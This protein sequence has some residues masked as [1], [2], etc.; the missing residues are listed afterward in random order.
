MVRDGGKHDLFPSALLLR[1][2]LQMA[3]RACMHVS[4]R[5]LVH[6]YAAHVSTLH[7]I[8]G[9]SRIY[10]CKHFTCCLSHSQPIMGSSVFAGFFRSCDHHRLSLLTSCDAILPK[11]PAI[12]KIPKHHISAICAIC[13]NSRNITFRQFRGF[14]LFRQI[15]LKIPACAEHAEFIEN[16]QILDMYEEGGKDLKC[17]GRGRYRSRKFARRGPNRPGALSRV[18]WVSQKRAR[19]GYI[20]ACR[21]QRAL[22]VGAPSDQGG[23]A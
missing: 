18:V 14:R 1:V 23:H 8:N 2:Q 15:L 9:S 6:F 7:H 19:R 10:A 21:S 22:S 20:L 3:C 11:I 16:F 13:R 17:L 12:P 5:K 4:L